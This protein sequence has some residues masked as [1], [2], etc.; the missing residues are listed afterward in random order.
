MQVISTQ[1]YYDN[2]NTSQMEK[3]IYKIDNVL[4]T[5]LMSEFVSEELKRERSMLAISIMNI[6]SSMSE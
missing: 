6:K 1:N 3:A 5:K 4:H 2:K